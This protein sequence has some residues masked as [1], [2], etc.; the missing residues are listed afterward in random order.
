VDQL[1]KLHTTAKQGRIL[2][3]GAIVTIVG[4]PNAGKSSL[5]NAL[6]GYERSIVTRVPGTT[7]DTIED[8]ANINDIPVRL[9]DT[10]G[11]REARGCVEATGI[12]RSVKQLINSD[13]LLHV[14]DS[15]RPYSDHDSQLEKIYANLTVIRVLNKLD[16]KIKILMPE[17]LNI[18]DFVGVSSV[19]GDGLQQL[20][21][22]IVEIL[23]E[24]M[25]HGNVQDAVVNDRQ[26]HAL[27]LALREIRKAL[28]VISSA[29][30]LEIA[31]H[32]LRLA[33][34]VIGE[35]TGRT[36][37]EDILDSVFKTFCIGK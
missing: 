18:N 7:R 4:R 3:D 10:A 16:K 8:I 22:R 31:S 19:T 9:H 36:S 6:L 29:T 2:R 17:H 23:N 27:V 37:T 33:L 34:N 21:T 28:R 12:K 26:N 25:Y 14:Y 5:M 24:G 15:S 32:H 1:E 11:F 30:D 13:L 20:R 35:I